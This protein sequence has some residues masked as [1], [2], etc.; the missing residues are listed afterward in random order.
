[1]GALAGAVPLSPPRA[2]PRIPHDV[3]SGS[4]LAMAL[5]RAES[6]RRCLCTRRRPRCRAA[7]AEGQLLQAQGRMRRRPP[8]MRRAMPRPA[9]WEIWN[10]LGNA[11][12]R[13][14]CRRRGGCAQRRRSARSAIQAIHADLASGLSAGSGRGISAA[15]RPIPP[16]ACP[17]RSRV[18]L[19][20]PCRLTLPLRGG[21]GPDRRGAVHAT[22]L[23]REGPHALGSL[24][25]Q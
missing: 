12:R 22:E 11:R 8:P 3:G 24:A 21:S 25:A 5:A 16:G 1:M 2:L 9:D 18:R 14:R 20:W 10:N 15:L 23:R 19:K 6:K 17:M 7:P 13:R 4:I